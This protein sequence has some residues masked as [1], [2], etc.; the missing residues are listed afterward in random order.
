VSELLFDDPCVVFALARESRPFLRQFPPHQDFPGA[1][2]PAWF[3]GPSWLTVLVLETGVGTTRA[4]AALTWLLGQ[5]MLE[6]VPYRPRVVL[7]AGFAGALQPGFQV[8]D[9]L[10]ATEVADHHGNCWPATW[11]G[12]LPPG[13]WW[14]PLHRGRLLTVAHLVGRPEEKQVLGRQYE[15]AAVDMETASVARLCGDHGVPLGCVRAISDDV[16]TGLSPRLLSLLADSRVS[17][18]RVL[19]ALAAAPGLVGELWRLARHTRKAARQLALALGELLT[20]TLPW[21]GEL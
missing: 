7:S 1:P 8:G 10:L 21:G 17:P 18:R 19:T 11:P 15:A 16:Q 12:E 5:P 4:E 9:I 2:C 20:L 3:C 13:E 6:K 14:P